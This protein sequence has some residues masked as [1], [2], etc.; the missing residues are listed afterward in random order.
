MYCTHKR[1][2]EMNLVDSD[3]GR[4]DLTGV[5][6]EGYEPFAVAD[7]LI[8]FKRLKPCEECAKAITDINDTLSML[9]VTVKEPYSGD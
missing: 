6:A 7:G 8:F 5:L 4:G 9:G 3:S 2:W 1:T